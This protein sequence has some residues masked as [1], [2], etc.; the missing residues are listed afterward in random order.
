MLK[1]IHDFKSLVATVK[2]RKIA[3]NN[4]SNIFNVIQNIRDYFAA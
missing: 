4:L 3:E 2:K 1:Y